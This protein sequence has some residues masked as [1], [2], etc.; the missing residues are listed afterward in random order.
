MHVLVSNSFSGAE[1]VAI[2]II[3]SMKEEVESAY[4]SPYGEIKNYL[5]NNKI[6]Y[7]PIKKKSLGEIKKAI[8]EFKPDLIHAHDFT[9]GVICSLATNLPIINHLH[10][11]SPW[12]RKYN[13][14]S[15]LYLLCSYRFRRILTVS[16]SVMNEYVFGKKLK[17]KTE[18]VGN[19]VDVEGVKKNAG[20]SIIKY[21]IA[22]LGRISTP[23]NP[24]FFVDI[25]FEIKKE[26]PDVSALM[27]GEGELRV[28]VENRIKV[29]KLDNNIELIGFQKNPYK[30]LNQA[31]VV[32]MPS[33][34][35]GYG[36]AAVEALAL[37]KPVVC[38]GVGGLS[39]IID[40]ECGSIC[41]EKMEYVYS[42]AKLL[43][44]ERCYSEAS[45]CAFRRAEKLNNF[46]KYCNRIRRLYLLF[47]KKRD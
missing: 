27:I 24:L 46:E 4:V 43:N 30:Y 2:S 3:N 19:P 45:I 7:I 17:K 11:N 31:R 18:V 14:R 13:F 22:F 32:L 21:D 9:A 25:I 29:L 34:W 23:K 6:F 16:D 20:D 1:S 12:I 15:Y 42:V 41:H 47:G 39:E 38:S 10:N 40:D 5:D 26:K 44:D 36:L 35:E 37:G 28:E 8:K 33:S